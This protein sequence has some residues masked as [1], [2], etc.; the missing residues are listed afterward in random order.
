MR[1]ELI[2]K[3]RQRVPS[4]YSLTDLELGEE[5]VSACQWLLQENRFLYAGINVKVRDRS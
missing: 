5:V 2:L 1:S 3:A 4:W